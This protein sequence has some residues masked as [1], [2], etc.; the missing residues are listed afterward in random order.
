MLTPDQAA[1]RLIALAR[2]VGRLAPRNHDPERFFV[3]RGEIEAELAKLA[4]ELTPGRLD[5]RSASDSRFSPGAIQCRGR[6]ILVTTRGPRRMTDAIA[7]ARKA[8]R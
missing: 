7:E 5:A 1:G 3:D 8:F 2:R 4:A 6:S